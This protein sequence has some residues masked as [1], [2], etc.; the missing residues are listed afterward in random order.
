MNIPIIT[1]ISSSKNILTTSTPSPLEPPVTIAILPVWIGQ[2]WQKEKQHLVHFVRYFLFLYFR[3]IV[4]WS[5]IISFS[6]NYTSCINLLNLQI[7]FNHTVTN[8]P[9]I[10]NQL[11]A[12]KMHAKYV[13]PKHF[14]WHTLAVASPESKELNTH[15]SWI[16][17]QQKQI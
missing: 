15:C 2:S 11:H 9:K 5:F 3:S 1:S 16:Y 17:L 13:N 10:S 14:S 8:V 12:E 4:S 7:Y 6:L